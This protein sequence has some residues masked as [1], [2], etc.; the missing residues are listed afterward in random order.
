MRIHKKLSYSR[1]QGGE[2]HTQ[3]VFIKIQKYEGSYNFAFLRRHSSKSNFR[4]VAENCRFFVVKTTYI[5]KSCRD[6]TPKRVPQ[7]VIGPQTKH[8]TDRLEQSE[9]TSFWLIGN[10]VN[11]HDSP[12]ILL[13]FQSDKYAKME[14]WILRIQNY[15]VELFEPSEN[16]TG[17]QSYM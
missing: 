11:A 15:H 17:F 6:L 2:L 9:V 13:R 4:T 1:R 14:D 16:F 10:Q 5:M 7:S 8:T 12:R 3:L